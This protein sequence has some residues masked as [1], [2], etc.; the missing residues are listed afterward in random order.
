MP[1][2]ASPARAAPRARIARAAGVTGVWL[3]AALPF[4]LGTARCPVARALHVACPGCGMSRA[5][6]L[7]SRGEIAASLAMHPLAAPTLLAQ[8]AFALATIAVTLDRGSPFALLQVRY[9]RF[10]VMALA[11]VFALVLAV[12]ALR[13]LGALGGPVPV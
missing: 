12:W 3:F 6:S 11:L 7:L 1:S 10:G 2:L 9:G 5:L 8:C 4:V 13:M